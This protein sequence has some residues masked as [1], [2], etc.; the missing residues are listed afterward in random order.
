MEQKN[1]L[2]ALMVVITAAG[3]CMVMAQ[4][5]S[6]GCTTS[7][8]GLSPCINFFTSK[9]GISAPLGCCT[10]FASFV[11]SSATCACQ[12][13]AFMPTNSSPLPIPSGLPINQT[14]LLNLPGICQVDT[15]QCQGAGAG[16]APTASPGAGVTPTASPDASV[17]TTG[18]TGE[19][20][21]PAQS[22]GFPLTPSGVGASPPSQ[23]RTSDATSSFRTSFFSVFLV[24]IIGSLL[25]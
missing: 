6:S 11:E 3:N 17:E 5:P 23:V 15:P 14:Q 20:Q 24:M 9:S 8:L 2:I 25:L 13:L 18:S 1:T 12:F 7:L 19:A 16:V 4:T 10:A 22:A 21:T